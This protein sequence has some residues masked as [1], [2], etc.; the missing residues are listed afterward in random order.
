M[1]NQPLTALKLVRLA[2]FVSP[3]E[4][5]RPLNEWVPPPMPL[6]EGGGE[7]AWELAELE[8]MHAEAQFESL[9]SS[10]AAVPD[11]VLRMWALWPQ[12]CVGYPPYI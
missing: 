3:E 10:T 7:K 4:W 2:E 8:R 5:V 6:G 12:S 9:V 11:R 1:A